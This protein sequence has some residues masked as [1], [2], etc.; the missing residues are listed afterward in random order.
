MLQ[1]CHL[2]LF[3]ID[4]EWDLCIEVDKLGTFRKSA[5]RGGLDAIITTQ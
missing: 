1:R 5:R 2:E 3:E 4:I